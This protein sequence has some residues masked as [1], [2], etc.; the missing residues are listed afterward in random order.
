MA[1]RAWLACFVIAVEC[2]LVVH[3]IRWRDYNSCP[4]YSPVAKR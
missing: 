1:E 2:I 3:F 4:A